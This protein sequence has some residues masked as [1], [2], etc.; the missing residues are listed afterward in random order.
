MRTGMTVLM[1]MLVCV[2]AEAAIV[3]E[4]IDYKAGDTA[5]QGYLAYDDAVAG[6]RPGV[7]VVHEWWGL[8][9]YPKDR[10]RTLAAL[11]Y[12][13]FAADMYGKGVVPADSEQAGW[14]AG[15]FHGKWDEGG[16]TLMRERARAGLAVLAANPRVDAPRL[17]AIGYCFGGT[18]ALELAY[19]GADLDGVVTFHGGLTVPTEVDLPNIKARFLILHGAEDPSVKPEDIKA[20][21]Q[22]LTKAMIDWQMVY[23]GGAVHAF[24]NP[25]TQSRP[26]QAE[27]HPIA[28]RRSWEAMKAFLAEVLAPR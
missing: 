9:D 3:T 25:E 21:Q 2:V 12:E 10:A 1:L 6:K 7:L 13:V 4:N 19:S 24:S 16:R 20:M 5:L 14:L 15:R 8:T 26:G 22:A 28:A 18:T 27:Y 11:G 23:Y 17:A